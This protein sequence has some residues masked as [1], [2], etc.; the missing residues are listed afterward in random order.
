MEIH[1]LVQGSDEWLLFRSQHFGASEAAAMLGLS[2]KVKRTELLHMK[3]TGNAKEFSDWVQANILDYGH[4]VEALARPIIEKI[5]GAVLYP[6]TCSEGDQS[7]SC[8]GL[9]MSGKVA[10][11]HK[12]WNILLADSVYQG[13]LPEEFMP[14]CQQV[15]KVTGAERLYFVVSDGT[16]E[17]FVYMEVLPDPAWFERI[18]AGWAQFAKDLATYEPT[19]YVEKPIADAIKQLPA[20]AI[21]INGEVVRSNLP[22]FQAAAERFIE[23]I[24]TDLT[25]DEDFATAEANVKFCKTA[26]DDL[27]G[28]KI[29]A[30]KQTASI[31][32]LM[33]TVD[34][35][36]DKLRTKRLVLEK[37]VVNQKAAIKDSILLK[38]KAE[39]SDHVAS[40]EKEIAPI[41]LICAVPDFAG[42]MK[43][44]KTMASLHDAAKTAVANG[45]I[46]ADAIARDL[47]SKLAWIKESH[48]DYGFL[49]KDLQQIIYKA[50]DDFRLT[51]NTRVG[52]HKESEK[53]KADAIAADAVKKE[54][55]RVA[56]EVAVS[57]AKI[58]PEP[59]QAVAAASPAGEESPAPAAR[60]ASVRTFTAPAPRALVIE[61]EFDEGPSDIEII[62]LISDTFGLSPGQTINRIAKMLLNVAREHYAEHAA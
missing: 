30:I 8:D 18:D 25:T 40:I 21:Q 6:V 36:K 50:D 54:Q 14:Q 53:L 33:R 5:I 44:K 26:E 32:E 20:L 12:Q 29:A 46:A 49:F 23:T 52:D 55:E 13:V 16:P 48:A 1:D 19:V 24:K 3:H 2:K 42:A 43:A 31:D 37:L 41:R 38:A 56:A 39:F 28:A 35:I 27:E 62:D 51:V 9:T 57:T 11:E 58:A 10:F 7:A 59:V 47:R 61:S 22:M 15:L 34:F 17:K 4:E 60:P 45:K